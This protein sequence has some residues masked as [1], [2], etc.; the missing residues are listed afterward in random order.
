MIQALGNLT[1][2]ESAA[3]MVMDVGRLPVSQ[4]ISTWTETLYEHYYPLDVAASSENFRRGQL[5]I[6]DLPGVRLGELDSDRYLVH[7]RRS[8]VATNGEDYYFIPMP[9]QQP[10]GLQQDGR[11]TLL[12]PGDATLIN[13]S[14]AYAYLQHTGNR[15]ATLRLDGP[16]L[17]ARL[18]FVD[19][20]VALPFSQDSALT[21]VLVDFV[22]SVLHRS[23]GLDD[24]AA[25]ALSDQIFDLIGLT[26]TAQASAA[27]SSE[28][29]VRLIHIRRIIREIDTKL[30]RFDMGV[31]VIAGSLG[32]SRRYIQRLVA[33][34]D[35]T[36]SGLIRDRRI[37]T[38]RRKLA[39]PALSAMSISSI[40]HS[41][42]FADP[43]HFSRAFR[44]VTDRSPGEYRRETLAGLMPGDRF[45]T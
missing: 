24:R 26:L 33:E 23:D 16:R 17:R 29:S 22:L 5:R 21:G 34:R 1:G 25:N 11:D 6:L 9:L 20:I 28:L 36:V 32:L 19:D 41:V 35:N 14:G 44:T 13:T 40:G 37:A 2:G 4:R 31:D 7:R 12:Q 3:M 38:A 45:P 43:A 30:D 39:D 8:H 18:P 10:L 27:E 15:I 42:G